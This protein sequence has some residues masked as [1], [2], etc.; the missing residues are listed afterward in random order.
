MVTLTQVSAPGGPAAPEASYKKMYE[1]V[2]SRE[3]IIKEKWLDKTKDVYDI[4]EGGK[5]G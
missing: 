2:I 3:K 5:S 1:D 4:Y